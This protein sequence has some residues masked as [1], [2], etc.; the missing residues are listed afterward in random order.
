[1][2]AG[3]P[4]RVFLMHDVHETTPVLM[5]TRWTLS[6]LRGPL[7]RSEVSVLAETGACSHAH[8]GRRSLHAGA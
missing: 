8:R 6:Y 2:L 3:L 4:G 5:H 7:T 1:M